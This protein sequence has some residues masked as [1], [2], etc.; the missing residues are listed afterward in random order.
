LGG[1]DHRI[2]YAQLG[3]VLSVGA[4]LEVLTG[5]QGPRARGEAGALTVSEERRS[6]RRGFRG[7]VG[8]PRRAATEAAG[9]PEPTL[10]RANASTHLGLDCTAQ[11]RLNAPRTH[12]RFNARR[13]WACMLDAAAL[14]R[15]QPS[16]AWPCSTP[17]SP[18]NRSPAVT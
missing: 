8:R 11:P 10:S 15:R 17:P 6:R 16:C 14:A 18:E 13:S 9:P 4:A 3:G 12:L 1:P 2:T 7:G 5:W